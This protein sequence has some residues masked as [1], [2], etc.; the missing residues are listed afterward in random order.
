[1]NVL[2][3]WRALGNIVYQGGSFNHVGISQEKR[4]CSFKDLLFQSPLTSERHFR[5]DRTE[6]SVIIKG[7]K[8]R[9]RL[10][11]LLK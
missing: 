6:C 8:K 3:N 7:L 1:M 4:V 11:L 10:R 9:L 5:I 2:C